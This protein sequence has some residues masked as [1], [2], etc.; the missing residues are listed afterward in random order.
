[1]IIINERFE[2]DH[3]LY[4]GF[5]PLYSK[6]FEMNIDLR[7]AVQREVFGHSTLSKGNIPQ[8]NS[9]F[10]HFMW[11][12]KPHYCEECLKP[13]QNYSSVWVSHI[14]SRGAFPEMAHDPRNVNILCDRHHTQWETGERR[15]MRIYKKNLKTIDLLNQDYQKLQNHAD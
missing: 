4:R 9:R 3:C 14:L 15:K 12:N 10:Y 8:A 2:Y 1:M 5:D 6:Y 13:L 11:E 7:V